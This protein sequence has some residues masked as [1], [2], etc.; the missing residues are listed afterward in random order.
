MN[1]DEVFIEPAVASVIYNPSARELRRM[2]REQEKTTIFG[3]A[4]YVDKVRSRSAKFT[5]NT[6]DDKIT[7]EDLKTVEEAKEYLSKQEVIC[8]DRVMGQ[9][10]RCQFICRFYI[11]KK[12]ARIAYAWGELLSKPS[13]EKQP[14][15]ITVMIPEFLE[16]KIL[17]H[18]KNFVTYVLGSD[19]TGEVK[20]SFLR[21]WMYKVKQLGGLGLHAGS[22]LVCTDNPSKNKKVGRLFFGLSATGKTTLTCHGLFLRNGFVKLYQDDVVG[23][24][25]DGSCVGTEGEGLF[26]KTYGLN[27]EEQPELFKA[28][29]APNAILENVWVYEDGGV[30]FY[31]DEL[32]RNGRASI[33]RSELGIASEKID[34]PRVDQLF[35]IT[36]NPLT[37]P[38]A[39]LTRE[40]AAV[41]FMLGESVESSAGDPER[42]GERIRIVGTNP[43][44]T[45]PKGEEG[46]K[47]LE[48]LHLNPR[49][50]CFLLNTGSIGEGDKNKDVRLMDTVNI[51][52]ALAND[53]VEWEFRPEL[54]FE[55][56][57]RVKDVNL[58]FNPKEYYGDEFEDKIR[59]LREERKEWLANFPELKPE[60]IDAVY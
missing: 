26:I 2:A 34:I 15:M 27:P 23:L 25:P 50:E 56:P 41:A 16:T 55:I 36:R 20:K 45:G 60:I 6:F 7:E 39:R 53:S 49:I 48:L 46:N 31:N 47:L 54:G 42:A 13:K 51:L 43:F 52:K 33:K 28:V 8:L 38:I 58:E 32:T 59:E 14:D 30:D 17:V 29:T 5:K 44:I 12:Y 40:Q 24:L 37:P 4:A 9:N 57:K 35:F 3:S 19:Y 21:M 22:K 18:P 11:T 1:L 10:K